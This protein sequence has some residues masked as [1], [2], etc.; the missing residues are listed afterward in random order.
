MASLLSILLSFSF[1]VFAA[2]DYQVGQ[3]RLPPHLRNC[4]EAQNGTISGTPV[5]PDFC[6][7]GYKWDVD[8]R[9]NENCYRKDANGI[10]YGPYVA[11]RLCPK[12]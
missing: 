4:F 2:Q 1:S 3:K 8:H 6:Q 7:V 12:K 5:D 11:D 9:L 10:A